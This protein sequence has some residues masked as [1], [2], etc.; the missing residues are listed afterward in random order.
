MLSNEAMKPSRFKEHLLKKHPD[1]AI[2]TISAFQKNEK[3]FVER[4]TLPMFDQKANYDI[5]RSHC[6]LLLLLDPFRGMRTWRKI[7]EPQMS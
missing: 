5:E 2:W 4:R 6:L 7:M 1:K 3:I